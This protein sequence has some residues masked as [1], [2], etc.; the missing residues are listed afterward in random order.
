MFLRAACV[1]SELFH[2]S[3][4]LLPAVTPDSGHARGFPHAA[5]LGMEEG[6]A[7]QPRATVHNCLLMQKRKGE[8]WWWQERPQPETQVICG[9]NKRWCFV[10]HPNMSQSPFGRMAAHLQ[11]AQLFRQ[12]R[13]TS[14]ILVHGRSSS[15]VGCSCDP[16]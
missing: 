3:P 5:E 11:N 2:T 1:P 12:Q 8:V 13:F 7:Y 16:I 4:L 9:K 14:Y 15:S 10:L 6:P